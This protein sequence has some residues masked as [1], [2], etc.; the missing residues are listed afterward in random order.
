MKLRF[1]VFAKKIITDKLLDNKEKT[2]N[3]EI[4]SERR[5]SQPMLW[6]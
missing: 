1:G 4:K 5:D 2:E 6:E 3:I